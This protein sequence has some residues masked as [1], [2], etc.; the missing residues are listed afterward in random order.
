MNKQDELNV[1]LARA[2]NNV[3]SGCIMG[4]KLRLKIA[5]I[6]IKNLV[7]KGANP[8]IPYT[9]EFNDKR[10]PI[11][12]KYCAVAPMLEILLK[13][14][15]DPKFR[16]ENGNTLAHY[17]VGLGGYSGYRKS[18]KEDLECLQLLK[19]YG[20]DIAAENN[21]GESILSSRRCSDEISL[22]AIENGCKP[23]NPIDVDKLKMKA[24]GQEKN[25]ITKETML[26]L[27]RDDA[28]ATPN[29]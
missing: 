6:Q 17:I 26:R 1:K 7:N 3:F 23:Q 10:D 27:H 11:I 18:A 4:G 9:D 8:N 13:N 12:T 5:E 24:K 22:F 29:H 16:D 20:A 14:G 19:K 21:N 28:K 15:G 2:C 25:P